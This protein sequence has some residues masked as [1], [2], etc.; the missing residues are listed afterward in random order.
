M[1]GRL[2]KDLKELADLAKKQL[3]L[4]QDLAKYEDKAEETKAALKLFSEET[5][6]AAMQK[7]ELTDIT[8]RGKQI[9]L[10]NDFRCNFP[11]LAGIQ[12]A[13]G[14]DKDRLIK[15]KKDGVAWMKKE[16]HTG[17]L[18]SKVT[19]EFGM[20]EYKSLEKFKEKTQKS[21]KDLE[22]GIA[23]GVHPAS[24]KKFLQELGENGVDYPKETFGVFEFKRVEI[25]EED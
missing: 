17:L 19:I 12:K 3:K 1:A 13:K 23:E 6:P 16:D 9:T 4:E 5:F 14:K 18:K 8:I 10:M 25:T 2:G 7:F 11:S 20:G 21:F 15:R 22:L 24:L